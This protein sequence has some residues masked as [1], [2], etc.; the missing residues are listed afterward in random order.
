MT[1]S[2]SLLVGVTG[3][4]LACAG[5]VRTGAIA[6]AEIPALATQA[7]QQ[8]NNAPV[9]FRLAAALMAAGRCDTAVVVARAG[10]ILDPSNALGPLVLGGCQE[11]DG[12]FDLAFATYSDFAAQHP[13]SRGVATVRAKAQF[14][15][16][17][18]AE[19]TARQ[20]LASES[21][22]TRAAPSRPHSPSSR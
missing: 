19:Q 1:V 17:S 13:K 21:T 3:L 16:R 10:Q 14:A 15:L 12:R 4:G 6:P 8:P 18:N 9:R 20:A 2:R 22:L 11:K 7:R 5:G